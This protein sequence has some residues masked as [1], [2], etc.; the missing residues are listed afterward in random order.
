MQASFQTQTYCIRF[1]CSIAMLAIHGHVTDAN[2]TV[3]ETE[4]NY[5]EVS[6]SYFRYLI[7]T[8][9]SAQNI[10]PLNRILVN[11]LQRQFT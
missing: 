6:N 10:A 11:S 7:T 8:E 9:T 1:A 2:V 3:N 4:R 5:T